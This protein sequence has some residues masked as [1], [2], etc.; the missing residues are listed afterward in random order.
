MKHYLFLTNNLFSM[1]SSKEYLTMNFSEEN[2]W[3]INEQVVFPSVPG[4]A[5]HF[6][7]LDRGRNCHSFPGVAQP[8]WPQPQG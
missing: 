1:P 4:V 7:K 3:L 5:V 8:I 6:L 2:Q